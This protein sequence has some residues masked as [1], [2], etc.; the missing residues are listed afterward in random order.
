MLDSEMSVCRVCSRG[1]VR[2]RKRCESSRRL[3]AVYSKN[4]DHGETLQPSKY[5]A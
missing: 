3:F 5:Y 1:R 4:L 2:G